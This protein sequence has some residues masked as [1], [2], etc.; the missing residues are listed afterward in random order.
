MKRSLSGLFWFVV[1]CLALSTAALPFLAIERSMV[2]W[3]PTGYAL[4][5]GAGIAF[6]SMWLLIL[7][8]VLLE[9]AGADRL[10]RARTSPGEAGRGVIREATRRQSRPPP[11]HKAAQASVPRPGT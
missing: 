3:G 10:L 4:L 8:A 11:R 1:N 2:D 9:K 7:A 6:V 5:I